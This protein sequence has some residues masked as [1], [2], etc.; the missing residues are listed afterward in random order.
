MGYIKS[1]IRQAHLP[2]H[3]QPYL[4]RNRAQ[5][6]SAPQLPPLSG[7]GVAQRPSGRGGA[8]PGVH[9]CRAGRQ[10]QLPAGPCSSAGA[11]T[12]ARRVRESWWVRGRPLGGPVGE[13]EVEDSVRGGAVAAAWWQVGG[14]RG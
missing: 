4:T 6:S 2:T 7:A 13:P 11:G 5:P 10:R 12:L 14:A 8:Q 3:T 1:W 9:E